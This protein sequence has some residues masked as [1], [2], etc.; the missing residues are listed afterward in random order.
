[1]VIIK[2]FEFG[3]DCLYFTSC[4]C[5]SKTYESISSY[6]P[7]IIMSQ[8]GEQTVLSTNLGE[9]KTVAGFTLL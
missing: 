8:K 7:H 9:G 4:Q 2:E 5:P 3:E 1:M 6:S